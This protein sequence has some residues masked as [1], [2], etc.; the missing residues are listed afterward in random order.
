MSRLLRIILALVLCSLLG[1]LLGRAYAGLLLGDAFGWV[2]G[3]VVGLA[4]GWGLLRLT[5][6]APR[7]TRAR[8]SGDLVLA[9]FCVLALADITAQ[10]SRTPAPWLIHVTAVVFAAGCLIV[11]RGLSRLRRA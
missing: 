1:A 8:A 10:L 9:A 5:L 11:M 3:L 2:A 4:L 6:A 7:G